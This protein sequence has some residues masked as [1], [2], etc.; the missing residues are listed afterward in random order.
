MTLTSPVNVAVIGSG[1]REHAL[2]FSLS[3]SALAGKIFCLPGNGGTARM[4]KVENVNIQVDQFQ[5]IADFAKENSIDLIVVGPDNP[6]AD[7]I[8]DFLEAK[9]LRVFGPTKESAK[10]EWSKAYAKRFMSDCELPTACYEIVDNAADGEEIV[11][12][13]SWARV[14]KVDGLALGKGVFVADNED[15][16][17]AALNTI[18]NDNKFGKAGEQVVIEERLEGEELSLLILC[19]GKTLVPLAPCQDHKRRL[20][21]DRGPNTGGMGAYSPVSLY[22]KCR[23]EI[24]SLVLAPLQKALDN[25][26]LKYKGVL[27]AGL[28]VA[29]KSD[30]SG[31]YIPYVLEFNARFGDPETQALLP[32]LDSDLLPV[33]WAC[34]DGTLAAVEVKW[35]KKASCCVVAVG[36]DY[37]ESS[38][39]GKEITIG[40]LPDDV[41]LFQAGTRFDGGKLTTNG[42]R[43][44]SV[45]ALGDNMES[46]KELAYRALS[47]ISFDDMDYRKDIAWRAAGTCLST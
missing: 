29:S 12:N 13:S 43:V 4:E 45:T 31:G 1:G 24:S 44:L 27:Y 11:R 26:I 20:E 16:A 32:R 46:A 18:F 10:L 23:N 21:G 36:R 19:D 34:T 22:D 30:G 25:G 28:M 7:G 3:Q 17:L 9:N 15:E 8:V 39:K 41:F 42:G 38:S 33:L 14:I 40:S 2:A 37:P 6:L 47:S 35:K 5:E